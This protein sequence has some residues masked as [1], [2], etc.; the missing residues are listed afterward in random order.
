MNIRSGI[1][2]YLLAAF[3]C[4]GVALQSCNNTETVIPVAANIFTGE[5]DGTAFTA[6]NILAAR[7]TSDLVSISGSINED[8]LFL[9]YFYG[10]E[11]GNYPVGSSESLDQILATL[12][13]ISSLDPLT[14]DSTI[15]ILL[16][17]ISEITQSG[18]DIL[19]PGESFGFYVLNNFVYYTSSGEMNLTAND[20][21]LLRLA[22]N[23]GISWLNFL[24]GRKNMT[25]DF[26]DVGYT[27]K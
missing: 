24:G 6:E 27:E 10:S 9:L 2:I 21:T 7:D 26:E 12:D 18:E 3:C 5:I 1:S 4:L 22:G 23:T 14:Q 13:S 25:A 8:A 17:Q 20:R 11:P 16:E 15:A 19:A